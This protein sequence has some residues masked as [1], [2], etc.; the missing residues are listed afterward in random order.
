MLLLTVEEVKNYGVA[1]YTSTAFMPSLVKYRSA[2]S[3]VEM[4]T[5]GER[6][7]RT[8]VVFFTFKD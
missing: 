5:H 6:G 1:V 3:K 7:E 2:V 8:N 4:G